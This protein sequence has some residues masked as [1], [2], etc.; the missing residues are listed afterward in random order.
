MWPIGSLFI[1]RVKTTWK[2]SCCSV[3]LIW[4]VTYLAV[5]CC[6]AA[7][8]VQLADSTDLLL[9]S[10]SG[11]LLDWVALDEVW[12]AWG[13]ISVNPCSDA[14]LPAPRS[15]ALTRKLSSKSASGNSAVSIYKFYSNIINQLSH[16]VLTVRITTLH[17]LTY[18][19]SEPPWLFMRVFEE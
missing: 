3:T 6:C 9:V 11:W 5:V 2:L 17:S 16:G 12:V 13:E 8:R 15:S 18:L 4:Y 14:F 7:C 19:L 10:M 1:N